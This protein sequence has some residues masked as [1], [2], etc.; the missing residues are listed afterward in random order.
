LS[1]NGLF[2]GALNTLT[3]DPELHH[4]EDFRD[5][6]WHR[7]FEIPYVLWTNR[8]SNLF[9]HVSKNDVAQGSKDS[10]ESSI[11]SGQLL[12]YLLANSPTSESYPTQMVMKKRMPFNNVIVQQSIV[13]LSDE[14]LYKRPSFFRGKLFE[15]RPVWNQNAGR[16]SSGT[17]IDIPRTDH[18]KGYRDPLSGITPLSN[19]S[20]YTKLRQERTVED[21][22]KRLI[23]ITN[24]NTDTGSIC[25]AIAE[26]EKDSLKLFFERHEKNAKYFSDEVTATANLWTTELHLSSYRILDEAKDY[27]GADMTFLGNETTFLERAGA[28]FRLTGDFFDRYWTCHVIGIGLESTLTFEGGLRKALEPTKLNLDFEPHKKPWKQRK[29]LELL[30]LDQMLGE[31]AKRYQKII[32]KTGMRLKELFPHATKEGNNAT[33]TIISIS[34]ELFSKQMNNG[35]YLIFR[36]TWPAFQYSLQVLEEDLTEVLQK[37]D[38]WTNRKADRAPEE[39]RWTKND[40]RRYRAAITKLTNDHSHTIRDLRNHLAT[41]RSLRISLSSGLQSTRDELN[42]LNAENIRYFTYLTAVFLP[43]GF[44]TGIWSM[45]DASPRSESIRGMVITAVITLLLT[46]TVLVNLQR[47]NE[48]LSRYTSERFWAERKEE[49]ATGRERSR[50]KMRQGNAPNVSQA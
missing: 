3:K 37:I 22:K 11:D 44:A 46:A 21:N 48:H 50:M 15:S 41:I 38:I 42:F 36:K 19:E 17:V 27:K 35:A 10:K 25:C 4:D 31:L 39:P 45:A 2:P 9:Q 24:L 13:E 12:K 26:H 16:T 5:A 43:L 49:F 18:T 1:A 6:Y 7:T 20:M 40:E 29:V 8:D 33:G 14:W 47:L 28:S 34:N 30:L 32:D 23:W